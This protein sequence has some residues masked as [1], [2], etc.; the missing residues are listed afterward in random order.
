MIDY[1]LHR[2][3]IGPPALTMEHFNED[4]IRTFIRAAA[5][6]KQCPHAFKKADP[7]DRKEH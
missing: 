4:R 6:P 7:T 5:A 3:A 2:M 1:L